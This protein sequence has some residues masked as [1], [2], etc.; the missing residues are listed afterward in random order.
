MHKHRIADKKYVDFGCFVLDVAHLASKIFRVRKPEEKRYLL[1]IVFSNLSL[2]DGKV[3]NSL[4]DI[5]Q[6]V[7]EYQK[8]KDVLALV[9]IVGTYYHA[10]YVYL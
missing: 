8:T 2:R 3:Q 4:K 10:N 7:L 9:D 1:N 6:A 5:F